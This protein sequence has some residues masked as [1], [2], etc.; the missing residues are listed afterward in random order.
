MPELETAIELL[1]IW[2]KYA[3]SVQTPRSYFALEIALNM[4][5]VIALQVITF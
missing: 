4:Q 3:D 2:Q 5:L 1:L